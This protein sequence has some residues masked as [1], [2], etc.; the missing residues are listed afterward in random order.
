[1]QPNEKPEVIELSGAHLQCYQAGHGYG[2]ADG[3]EDA[4]AN[5]QGL[6]RHVSQQL[7]LAAE[8]LVN[9][10]PPDHK[11]LPTIQTLPRL[12]ASL[13]GAARAFA[14][15]A[16]QHRE[17]ATQ[18]VGTLRSAGLGLRWW[19]QP[20]LQAGVV[21]VAAVAIATL[22]STAIVSWWLHP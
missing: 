17:A 15:K 6:N 21:F 5:L 19:Q 1:M 14:S 12:A 3:L 8:S 18:V 11:L 10:L 22:T 4:A 9:Q 20:Q 2:V 16:K 7:V 13:E